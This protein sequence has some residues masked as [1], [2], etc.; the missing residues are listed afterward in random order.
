MR[1]FIAALT[2]AAIGFG[3]FLYAV[4]A[5][6]APIPR[7]DAAAYVFLA[8]WIGTCFALVIIAM[9]RFAPWIARLLGDAWEAERIRRDKE[10]HVSW[11]EWVAFAALVVRAVI[12][13]IAARHLT[14]GSMVVAAFAVIPFVVPRPRA[15]TTRVGRPA[16]AE[17]R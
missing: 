3:Q 8:T 15:K 1:G 13:S 6:G 14:L 16:R 4:C 10:R 9:Y 11:L 17:T 12:G 2:G 5:D 7:S